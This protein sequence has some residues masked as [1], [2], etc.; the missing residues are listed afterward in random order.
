[1][2]HRDD[3]YPPE[4]HAVLRE[5]Q[6]RHFWYRGRHR[7][8][9][10]ATRRWRRG[11]DALSAI[12][13]GCGCGAWMR[14][15]SDHDGMNYGELAVA[16]SSLEALQYAREVLPDRV[17]RHQVDL[18]NLRW[19]A[20]WDL[21]SLLDVIEHL[22]DDTAAMAEVARALKP[23]GVAIVSV[24]A[25]PQLW[26][27]NDELAGH[28]RRYVRGDFVRLASNAGLEL[29]DSRYFMCLLSPLLFLSRWSASRKLKTATR[30]EIRRA[31]IDMHRV[32]AAPINGLLSAVFGLETYLGH[33]LRLPFGSSLLGVFRRA[34]TA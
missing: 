29:C 9:L 20:R 27:F 21:I 19:S 10:E 24:P 17:Q 33:W 14:Y 22:P 4:F 31:M 7:F 34:A 2:C 6:S 8:V 28:Q 32:P 13:L 25:M 11:V 3:E 5:M 12:D 30:D 15:L 1:L 23:G 26:S 16:D 18:M